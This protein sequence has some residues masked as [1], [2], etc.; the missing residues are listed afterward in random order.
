[1]VC[2]VTAGCRSCY[3][4]CVC[5]F[6]SGLIERNAGD[7]LRTY[8]THLGESIHEHQLAVAE[9]GGGER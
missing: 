6:C 2:I 7:G 4:I 1:M 3:Y 5:V 8:Y 9:D